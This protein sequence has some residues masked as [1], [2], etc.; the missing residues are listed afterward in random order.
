MKSTNNYNPKDFE[1]TNKDYEEFNKPF[2]EYEFKYRTND[3]YLQ[4]LSV[5]TEALEEL[6]NHTLNRINEEPKKDF[7]VYIDNKQEIPKKEEVIINK[8][9]VKI[10]II[11]NENITKKDYYTHHSDYSSDSSDEEFF[12][13][14]RKNIKR[15]I[16]HKEIKKEE[17]IIEQHVEKE[18]E[19]EPVLSTPK[20]SPKK[21]QITSPLKRL[22]KDEEMKLL[23]K[24]IKEGS[25]PKPIK[26][27]IPNS[28]KNDE[29]RLNRRRDNIIKGLYNNIKTPLFHKDVSFT[30]LIPFLPTY[31][32]DKLFNTPKV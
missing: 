1:F 4:S 21:I 24:I 29:E 15:I 17:I 2:R 3:D 27:I 5:M 30:P 12:M 13:S 22:D 7:V 16:Q 31:L 14:Q 8:R 26:S 6:S 11:N 9:E 10:P 18:I 19:N 23:Q 28:N 20:K 25:P 32:W